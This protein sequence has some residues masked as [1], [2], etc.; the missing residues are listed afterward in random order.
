MAAQE[1]GLAAK[2]KEDKDA[3]RKA[4][5]QVSTCVD[6]VLMY[7]ER[8]RVGSKSRKARRKLAGFHA[9]QNKGEHALVIGSDLHAGWNQTLAATANAE[10]D[11]RGSK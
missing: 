2:V 9:W 11:S 5:E 8:R 3:E 10:V 6:L 1:E 7:A 4:K